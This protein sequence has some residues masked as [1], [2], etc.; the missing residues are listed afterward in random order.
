MYQMNAY[1]KNESFTLTI[2]R[3][4]LIAFIF[5]IIVH[6]L[7]F[8]GIP[9][10]SFKEPP[11]PVSRSFEVSLLKRQIPTKA[12][13]Q[14]RSAINIPKASAK[15]KPR[16]EQ[17]RPRVFAKTAKDHQAIQVPLSTDSTPVSPSEP[18]RSGASEQFSADQPITDMAS[19]VKAQQA[20]RAQAEALAAQHNAQ[21]IARERGRIEMN[22]GDERSKRNFKYGTNGI[23]EITSLGKTQATFVF[24]G[25]IDDYR[26]AKRQYF[27]VE[28]RG[29]E[30]IRL[31]MIRRMIELI[32]D[33]YDGDFNWE[34]QRLRRTVVLSARLQDSAELED[35]LMSEFFGSNYKTTRNY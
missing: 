27:D 35:F 34:S 30:D 22:F 17:K 19:Y 6:L 26:S 5:S 2:N 10:F 33:H 9:Q 32:R 16:A 15:P 14:S 28:T 21:A 18:V 31:V 24:Y 25:W 29:G 13:E 1:Q 12:P 20:K 7:L 3:N 8:F 4:V 11:A 23:F